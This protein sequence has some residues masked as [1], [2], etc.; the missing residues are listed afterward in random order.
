MRLVDLL[1]SVVE[2]LD[3]VSLYAII[4]NI[5]TTPYGSTAG[6]SN[7]YGELPIF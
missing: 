5:K 6:T 7:T 1:M 3:L 4:I 2:M